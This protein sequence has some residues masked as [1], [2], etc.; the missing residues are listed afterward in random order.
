M[1]N[2]KKFR[3]FIAFIAVMLCVAAFP[4]TAFAGG[5]D[6]EETPPPPESTLP[7]PPV[8]PV[9][10]TPD[11]NLALVDDIQGEQAEDKQFITVVTKNGNYFYIVI[12]RA[13]DEQNVY[14]LNLV[15]EADIQRL[16]EE[17]DE[18]PAEPVITPQP[19]PQPTPEPTPDPQPEPEPKSGG[20]GGILAIVLLL[21]TGGGGA[22]YYFKI[23]KPK[24][25]A[26]QRNTA[27]DELEFE[28]EDDGEY[29]SMEREH[30]ATGAQED[31]EE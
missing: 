12:D 4:M 10:L 19:E 16:L 3:M 25:A 28:D 15:D 14:F 20:I 27:F 5:D 24:K 18:V 21:G 17:M 9:P 7:T 31:D 2:R 6:P 1:K 8:D 23:L 26:A 29:M 11:G 30:A 13:G 22:Y